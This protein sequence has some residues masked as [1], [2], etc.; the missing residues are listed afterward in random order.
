MPTEAPE[1]II[2]R[3]VNTKSTGITSISEIQV[4]DLIS[5]GPIEGLVDSEITYSGTEGSIGW[6]SYVETAYQNPPGL[7]GSN[8][9]RSIYL[10]Q[11]PIISS[12]NKYNYQRIDISVSNGEA[13]GS[14]DLTVN[15]ELTVSRGLG[16]RLRASVITDNE[17]QNKDYN[18]IYRILN[19]NCKGCIVN[20]KVPRLSETKVQT[21]DIIITKVDYKIYYKPIYSNEGKFSSIAPPNQAG[22]F[23]P[24]Q[25]TIE[26]KVTYPYIRS[27]RINFTSAPTQEADFIGWEIKITRTTPDSLSAYLVNQTYIDSIT[28]IYEDIY[29]Y[30]YSAIIKSRY[31]SEFFSSIPQRAFDVR[32]L[33]VKIPANYDPIKRSYANSGPGTTNGYWNGQFADDLAWTN[34]PAWC[35]YDLLTNKRYGL[36][37]YISENQ[38]DKFSLYK[39]AQYCDTLVPDGY[40]GLEPRFTCNLILNSKEEAYKVL[41]DIASIFNGMTYYSN[42]SIYVSQDRPKNPIAIF[43]NTNVENGN[44][45]FSSSSKKAR[46]TVAIVR[47]NDPRN[48]F[49]PAIEYYQDPDGI[50]KY[51]LRQT[52]LTAFG[53]TS[54]GQAARLGRWT[55]LSQLKRPNTVS[56]VAGLEASRLRPGDLIAVYD[57]HRK[58]YR[59]TGRLISVTTNSSNSVVTLDGSLN[60]QSGVTYYFNLLTPTYNYNEQNITDLNSGDEEDIQRSFV[61]KLE[62]T[63]SDVS[64]NANGQT[65]ITFS[66]PFNIEDYIVER[67]QIWAV[68]QKATLNS[69]DTTLE[70]NQSLD[71]KHDYFIIIRVTETDDGKYEVFGVQYLND[72]YTDV[73]SG[74]SF[75][76][77]ESVVQAIPQPPLGLDL[78]IHNVTN[79]SKIIQ[80]LITPPNTTLGTTSYKI[81]VN[82]VPFTS[83][84]VPS[85][86]YLIQTLPAVSSPQGIYT[87]SSNG[88]YYFRVYSY[89]DETRT[90]SLSY[91]ENNISVTDLS[92][93]RDVK[94]SSLTIVGSQN[95]ATESSSTVDLI[96]TDNINPPFSWQVGSTFGS[97]LP[98]NLYYRW[99]LR[100]R[101]ENQP[102]PSPNIY[103]EVTGLS[104][105]YYNF[106][107]TTNAS[108]P[109][110][111]YKSGEVVVEA[112]DELFNT[113]AGN[114]IA[115]GAVARVENGW[116]S[117]PEG[118]DRVFFYTPNQS[119]LTLGNPTGTMFTNTIDSGKTWQYIDFNGGV[120]VL[121]SKNSLNSGIIG[122][123]IYASTGQFN[124]TDVRTGKYDVVVRQFF[125]N[126][127]ERYAYA[128][129]IFNPYLN[130]QTGWMALSVYDVYEY[131]KLLTS[132]NYYTGLPISNI[133]QIYATGLAHSLQIKTKLDFTNPLNHT[134]NSSMRINNVAGTG[135]ARMSITEGSHGEVIIFSKKP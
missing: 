66:A 121:F 96:S 12:D 60:L 117:N 34:N 52:E 127:I 41:N 78:S 90:F 53:C 122:G 3:G 113:S 5:E 97:Q 16:E 61:Q 58:L 2:V 17:E 82:T 131:Q 24:I 44:F 29:N 92:L 55:I 84:S 118:Y 91:I 25:E 51:G 132:P 86:D 36:G 72:I 104:S 33:K 70:Y 73:S 110:G 48:F 85:N 38:V 39:I 42:G 89:N 107:F 88:Q 68:E 111:P 4:L 1:G 79:N 71:E 74:L 81:Y 67:N 23:G 75:E 128:P 80:Y 64:V 63:S 49:A 125:C 43:N 101:N 115:N 32:L 65:V 21:G 106:D 114:V 102:T 9:L 124:S 129:A 57:A 46:N 98:N 19:K 37:E 27:T 103:Y 123:F 54:K 30:P 116:I 59:N 133:V 100:E 108:L 105:P 28:E 50:R 7:L 135:T 10:N 77:S 95:V 87:P 56:F 93:I 94:I 40:G 109:G 15:G 62:F 134:D 130:F 6:D 45:E 26:G 14:L 20:V 120:N 31:D 126:N 76:R 13:N 83:S 119:V 35:Y 69:V 11:V 22:Y 8:W 18:K 112:H 47:Y 99:T